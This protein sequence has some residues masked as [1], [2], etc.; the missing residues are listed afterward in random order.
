MFKFFLSHS[1]FLSNRNFRYFGFPLL[2]WGSDDQTLDNFAKLFINNISCIKQPRTLYV[3]CSRY[4]YL[5]VSWELTRGNNLN[6]KHDEWKFTRLNIVWV[7]TVLDGIFS[8]GVIW[9]GIFCV[10][11]ILRGNFPGGNCP[12]GSYPGWELSGWEFSEWELSWELP[13]RN[14]LGGNFPGRSF[15]STQIEMQFVLF[16]K[17]VF[18]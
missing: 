14:H 10:V 9:M 4:F 13:S 17:R 18:I 7:E 15:P 3:V 11:I 8:I 6:A 5:V 12:G 1:R 2:Q 16:T